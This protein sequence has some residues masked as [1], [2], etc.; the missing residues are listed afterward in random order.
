MKKGKTH[1]RTQSRWVGLAATRTHTDPVSRRSQPSV[2]NPSLCVCGDQRL[3]GCFE[4]RGGPDD[5]RDRKR[6]ERR[7]GR[8]TRE[9]DEGE[10]KREKMQKMGGLVDSSQSR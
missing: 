6:R 1:K 5:G 9:S 10:R 3:K 7:R 4:G 8:E 2:V